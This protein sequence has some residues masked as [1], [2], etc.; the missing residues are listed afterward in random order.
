LDS[1]LGTWTTFNAKC[2]WSPTY[3]FWRFTCFPAKKTPRFVRVFC[4]LMQMYLCKNYDFSLVFFQASPCALLQAFGFQV[5][6]KH[7]L[8]SV[9]IM[10]LWKC[11]V[12][13][14]HKNNV[15]LS[16]NSKSKFNFWNFIGTKIKFT[17]NS[18]LGFLH[19]C[20]PKPKPFN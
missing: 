4:M 10:C 11:E 19:I 1:N 3:S 18:I 8:F 6:F 16:L 5:M 15:L 17:R 7:R 14:G 12:H 2:I 13:F 9:Y 20:M